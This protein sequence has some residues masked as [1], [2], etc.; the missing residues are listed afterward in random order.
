MTE[1]QKK[2][3]YRSEEAKLNHKERETGSVQVWKQE[4]NTSTD[5]GREGGKEGGAERSR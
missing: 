3:K 5:L 1:Q 2:E 4:V